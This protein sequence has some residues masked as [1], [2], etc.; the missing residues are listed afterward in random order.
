MAGEGQ[1][2]PTNPSHCIPHRDPEQPILLVVA[3]HTRGLW[4][5]WAVGVVVP[6]NLLV[7]SLFLMCLLEAPGA[8]LP[9]HHHPSYGHPSFYGDP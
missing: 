4:P 2:P 6:M 3:A 8:L 1:P 9:Q 7:A 5:P